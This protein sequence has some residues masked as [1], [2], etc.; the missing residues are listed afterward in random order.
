MPPFVA[1][2][3]SVCCASALA[4]QNDSAKP[5]AAE[6]AKS[7]PE[8][9]KRKPV[10]R[11]AVQATIATM[12]RAAPPLGSETYRPVLTPPPVAPAPVLPGPQTLNC[13]PAGC[14]DAGGARVNNGVGN[15]TVGPQGQL[16]N[17][18]G[19]AVQCF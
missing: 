1:V 11:R 19:N 15:A 4:Q 12:P 2:L 6:E 17:R 10:K 8:Q 3:F 16:C 9:P 14:L 13:G 18:S 5:A 7:A